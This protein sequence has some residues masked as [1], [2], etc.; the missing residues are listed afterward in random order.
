MPIYVV[1][2]ETS[3]ILIGHPPV[4]AH[5]CAQSGR[6]EFSHYAAVF[7]FQITLR[8]P[9]AIQ[10]RLASGLWVVLKLLN[11]GL[12]PFGRALF[13]CL[14]GHDFFP[15]RCL[16]SSAMQSASTMWMPGGGPNGVAS[17]QPVVLLP[18]AG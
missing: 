8:L 7:G 10:H 5:G 1:P 3:Q 11:F 18:P 6:V 14:L 9:P 16:T 13:R 2:P 17:R 12:Q 4:R 15:A